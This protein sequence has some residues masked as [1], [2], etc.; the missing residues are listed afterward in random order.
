M[1]GDIAMSCIRQQRD[2][3]WLLLGGQ[4]LQPHLA[5]E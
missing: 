3:T 1:V 5:A 4:V 2:E